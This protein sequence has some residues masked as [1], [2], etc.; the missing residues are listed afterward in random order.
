M[1]I[2]RKVLIL[3]TVALV[4]A[5]KATYENYKVFQ[6]AT[7]RQIQVN[8]L[9]Q[10][11]EN[12]VSKTFY[13]HFFKRKKTSKNKLKYIMFAHMLYIF[14]DVFY[15]KNLSIFRDSNIYHIR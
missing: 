15:Y 1:I 4:V 7:P 8:L 11:E 3:C 2:M 14:Y 13:F 10:F 6:I 5:Q 12:G 9:N